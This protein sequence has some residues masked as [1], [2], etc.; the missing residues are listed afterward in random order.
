MGRRQSVKLIDD[1]HPFVNWARSRTRPVEI[2]III[3]ILFLSFVLERERDEIVKSFVSFL[4][5][6]I[7]Y[8]RDGTRCL[9]R[10]VFFHL[11]LKFCFLFFC[12]GID[13]FVAENS[14]R[15]GSKLNGFRNFSETRGRGCLL[16]F[17]GKL[18]G[19]V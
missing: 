3:I 14:S 11:V 4:S 1:F 17:D 18:F 15:F 19:P 2:I 16:L 6:E 10:C 8:A 12:F 7:N 5:I 13:L 9:R